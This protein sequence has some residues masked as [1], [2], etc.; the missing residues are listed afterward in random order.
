MNEY[1]AATIRTRDDVFL[2]CRQR[3]RKAGQGR[4][5]DHPVERG[6]L[7]HSE[8]SL[9]AY[10][11]GR[12]FGKKNKYQNT[13][14]YHDGV[15]YASQIEARRAKELDLLLVAGDIFDWIAQPTRRLGVAENVYKPDFLVI[16][17]AAVGWTDGDGEVFMPDAWYED[18]KGRETAKFKRD[19]KLWRRF[20][21]LPLRILKVKGTALVCVETIE[22][23]NER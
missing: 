8:A 17:K 15:R 1:C 18:V 13:P 12:A 11:R 16:G 20:G 14:E 9:S 6:S 4:C 10:L 21:R 3:A 22:G 2:R 23:G 19:V 7:F 5:R